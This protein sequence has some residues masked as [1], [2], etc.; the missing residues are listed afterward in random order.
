MLQ[1]SPEVLIQQYQGLIAAESL[2]VWSQLP[3]QTRAWIGLDDMIAQGVYYAW[4]KL[5]KEAENSH[6]FGDRR[7]GKHHRWKQRKGRSWGNY[8]KQSLYWDFDNDYISRNEQA[9]RRCET[10]TVSIDQLAANAKGG[11]ATGNF[12]LE[13]VMA[14]QPGQPVYDCIVVDAL[15]KVYDQAS[16]DLQ[17]EMIRWFLEADKTKFHLTGKRFLVQRSEF[18]A[19]AR[20]FRVSID[21]CRHVMTSS[22]CLDL[23]SRKARW[24]PYNINDP[25]PGVRVPLYVTLR[26][27]QMQLRRTLGIHEC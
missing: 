24:V 12:Q 10:R 7:R 26:E 23:F 27:Q 21:D 11:E 2:K 1:V 9:K 5:H 14:N 22:V 15:H 18:R 17:Q 8:L 6:L 13:S 19:L 25:T 4:R 20:T 3:K 16:Q